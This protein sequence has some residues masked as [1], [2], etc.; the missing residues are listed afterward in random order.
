MS[1]EKE[2]TN[3]TIK[4]K[5]GK[6]I[7]DAKFNVFYSNSLIMCLSMWIGN[8]EIH[9]E[10]REKYF[11]TNYKNIKKQFHVQQGEIA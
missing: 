3:I 9:K 1:N 10:S 4:I 5:F 6:Y 2:N 8:Q 11:L 7:T